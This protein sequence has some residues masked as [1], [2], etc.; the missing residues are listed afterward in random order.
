MRIP[1][2]TEGEGS[3]L[4][5]REKYISLTQY[6][7]AKP[8]TTVHQ[9]N[10][11]AGCLLLACLYVS[12]HNAKL[13]NPGHRGRRPFDLLFASYCTAALPNTNLLTTEGCFVPHPLSFPLFCES[14][15]PSHGRQVVFLCRFGSTKH[16]QASFGPSN[17]FQGAGLG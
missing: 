5:L 7:P 2:H 10:K 3:E 17:D 6:Q 12:F 4:P 13:L 14:R 16:K 9:P 11:S 8:L 15:P 1:H